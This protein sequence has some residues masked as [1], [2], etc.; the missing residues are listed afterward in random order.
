VESIFPNQIGINPKWKKT[1]LYF[2]ISHFTKRND[3]KMHG[4]FLKGYLHFLSLCFSSQWRCLVH[5]CFTQGR[6]EFSSTF[7]NFGQS[8]APNLTIIMCVLSF[9]SFTIC[10]HDLNVDALGT[11]IV[12]SIYLIKG[13]KFKLQKKGFCCWVSCE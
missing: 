2:E 12:S 11:K 10:Q 4:F 8:N 9:P 5:L 1:H 13:L 3:W 6:S 7:L